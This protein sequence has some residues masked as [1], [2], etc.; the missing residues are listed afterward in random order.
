M[1]GRYRPYY[2]ARDYEQEVIAK[3]K[4]QLDGPGEYIPL[5]RIIDFSSIGF[6]TATRGQLTERPFELMSSVEGRAYLLFHTWSGVTHICEQMALMPDETL[7]IA[8]SLGV[9]HPAVRE[10]KTIMSTDFV[11]T[12][13]T[14][15]VPRRKAY[16]VKKECDL[17]ERVLEKL[18]IEREYWRRRNIEWF[19]L[20][21]TELPRVPIENVALVFDRY[22][23]A[24][25][26]CD[27]STSA[28]VRDW[29]TPHVAMENQALRALSSRCDTV[30]RLEPGT[31]LSVSYH[32]IARRFWPVDFSKPLL[33]IP[34]LLN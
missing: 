10:G 6:R 27:E 4:C 34:Q 7:A 3:G 13:A 16:A 12:F 5:F 26:P 17:T 23:P 24:S 9:G 28:M 11:L 1:R 22:D 14:S 18:A 29:L 30:L 19:L 20:L 2:L 33:P 31:A 8:R 32:L 21:D 25:L 15:A